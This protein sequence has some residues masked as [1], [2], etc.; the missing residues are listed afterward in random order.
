MKEGIKENKHLFPVSYQYA[1]ITEYEVSEE[2]ETKTLI[3]YTESKRY[4]TKKYGPTP[5][6]KFIDF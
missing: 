4:Q 2:N 5:F 3:V 6:F 1:E